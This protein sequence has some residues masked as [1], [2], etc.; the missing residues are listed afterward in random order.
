MIDFW[1]RFFGGNGGSGFSPGGGTFPPPTNPNPFSNIPDR[2]GWPP[3]APWMDFGNRVDPSMTQLV[4]GIDPDMPN[5]EFE[6]PY[7]GGGQRIYDPG[8]MSRFGDIWKEMYPNAPS[9]GGDRNAL[10]PEERSM[11]GLPDQ[12]VSPGNEY[13][14]IGYTPNQANDD[15]SGPDFPPA[16]PSGGGY[17]YSPQDFGVSSTPD[18][19]PFYINDFPGGVSA[20]DLAN[21]PSNI[22]PQVETPGGGGFGPGTFNDTYPLPG[23][24]FQWPF[25]ISQFPSGEGNITA[26]QLANPPGA[27][28][29][30]E[31]QWPFF[32]D[33]FPTPGGGVADTSGGGG[34]GAT[35]ANAYSDPNA[36]APSANPPSPPDSS[37]M[38][39]APGF[40]N[41]NPSQGML[42]NQG[43]VIPGTALSASDAANKYNMEQFPGGGGVG[44]FFKDAAG[45]IVNGAGQ[46]VQ[47]AGNAVG[48][49]IN[50]I[51]ND[52]GYSSPDYLRSM[53]YG[54]GQGTNSLWPGTPSSS[55]FGVGGEGGSFFGGT[56]NFNPGGGDLSATGGQVISSSVGPPQGGGG[57][58]MYGPN[59]GAAAW[60]GGV[61]GLPPI[62]LSYLMRMYKGLYTTPEVFGTFKHSMPSPWASQPLGSK[63]NPGW[64]WNTYHQGQV[65]LHD[66]L[67]NNPAYFNSLVAARGGFKGK[68]AGLI[69][70]GPPTKASRHTPS[71]QP[72]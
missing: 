45:N 33:Q 8:E 44:Q 55:G 29:P 70:T 4:P 61:R 65:Q 51:M 41:A 20:G 1:Q 9:G 40:V 71:L 30:G 68:G 35:P 63:M 60:G 69:A 26:D 47:A 19:F 13:Q 48:G 6:Q 12:N 49:L 54:E 16:Y 31:F 15:F 7:R 17:P 66:L 39:N 37:L 72:A 18:A 10:T 36:Y 23:N 42:D 59:M 50:N 62:A 58:P 46:I 5:T 64:N 27:I 32:V 11:M 24:D 34:G 57:P 67:V 14:T 43:N 3:T 2:Y 21:V 38:P 25:D 52:P 53:G 22:G 56:M 28:G